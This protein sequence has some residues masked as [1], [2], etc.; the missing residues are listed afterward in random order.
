MKPIL[1]DGANVAWAHGNS[2]FPSF[3]GIKLASKELVVQGYTVLIV[4]NSRYHEK[5]E[6]KLDHL[7][8]SPGIFIVPR[9]VDSKSDDRVMIDFATNK[10][11]KILTNDKF[12]DHIKSIPKVKRE[13]ARI[14]VESNIENFYF[15]NNTFTLGVN[16]INEVKSLLL[17]DELT[18]WLEMKIDLNS[19]YDVF[20]LGKLLSSFYTQTGILMPK[21]QQFIRKLKLDKSVR[22]DKIFQTLLSN[23][24]LCVKGDNDKIGNIVSFLKICDIRLDFEMKMEVAKQIE[25][26]LYSGWIDGSSLAY[27]LNIALG[28]SLNIHINS[29][30]L[31]KIIGMPKNT[32]FH[33]LLNLCLGN[34][35]ITLVT[36]T[37]TQITQW[38]S[39]A[40]SSHKFE[41]LGFSS[42][43]IFRELA[44]DNF[45]VLNFPLEHLFPEISL[46]FEYE[47]SWT[48][49]LMISNIASEIYSSTG[50]SVKQQYG[51]MN[52][53][54]SLINNWK[55]GDDKWAIE[56]NHIVNNKEI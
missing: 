17:K 21:K 35:L 40:E 4:L 55:Y 23:N 29:T 50:K 28:K 32:K 15:E 47:D 22:L 18:A 19:Q 9:L 45:S 20:D 42:K 7:N 36:S 43:R 51:S 46:I 56:K 34:R 16:E 24:Y 48:N 26:L 37:S 30:K 52:M 44:K 31:L 13:M 39:L 10:K 12:R 49:G 27:N 41:G 5:W 54:I 2:L 38:Y 11:C 14:W 8:N 33:D 1:I 3:E 6:S 53:L 25:G